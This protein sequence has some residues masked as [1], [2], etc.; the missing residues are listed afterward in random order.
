MVEGFGKIPMYGSQSSEGQSRLIGIETA[1]RLLRPTFQAVAARSP[2]AVVEANYRIA[3]YP[4]RISS[5]GPNQAANLERAFGHLRASAD[6]APALTV[7]IWD[8]EEV[9][10]ANWAPWPEDA[11]TNGTIT[12][13]DDDRYVLTQRRGSVMLLDRRDNNITGC[14]RGWS[15]LYQDERVRPFHRLLSIWL[16][17]R[18]IQFIHAALVAQDGKGLLFV[19]KGG[20]GKSTSSITCYLGGMDFLSDD[21][22]AL[23]AAPNGDFVG[24]SLYDTFLADRMD[25]FPAFSQVAMR[26]NYPFEEKEGVFLRDLPDA[27]LAA[28][29]RIAAIVLPRVVDRPDIALSRVK[30]MEALRAAAP[31]S[32]WILPNSANSSLEKLAGLITSVPSFRLELGRDM[33]QVAPT[34][35]LLCSEL[36]G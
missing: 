15:T 28:S 27:R 26:P 34:A 22:V 11:E 4:V 30:P 3:G 16:D 13:S 14:V 31:S 24:H 12:I 23:E 25:R 18:N 5:A 8:D 36:D 19:G 17:D 9:G 32:L 1:I 6:A 2:A 21:Y 33:T 7:D 20:S 35:R 29:A 10:P